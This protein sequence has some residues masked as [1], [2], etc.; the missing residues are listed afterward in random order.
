MKWLTLEKIKAQCRIELDFHD[1][2]DW[3]IDTGEADEE[4]VLNILGRSYENLIETYGRVP[5]PIVKAT[6]MLVDLSYQHRSPESPQQIYMVQY[7]F[8]LMIKPYLRLAAP[9]TN[10]QNQN[11]YGCKNL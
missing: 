1:E 10:G 2:D 5:A 11:Q 4:A 8:D 6:L 3:L 7:T 9:S